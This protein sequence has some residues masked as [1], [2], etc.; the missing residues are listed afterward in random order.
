M[1]WRNDTKFHRL[2]KQC[3]ATIH[4]G[5]HDDA[6]VGSKVRPKLTPIPFPYCQDI[7][8]YNWLRKEWRKT[9]PT[10]NP[11]TG[12]KTVIHLIHRHKR[13]LP[14]GQ[15]PIV[16]EECRLLGCDAVWRSCKNHMVSYPRR[17]TTFFIVTA[18]KTLNLTRAYSIDLVQFWVATRSRLNVTEK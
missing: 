9:P 2:T 14:R 17:P 6:V 16:L 8:S 13:Q 18:V 7:L 3:S 11:S 5:R 12:W 4:R 15:E 1:I 10:L